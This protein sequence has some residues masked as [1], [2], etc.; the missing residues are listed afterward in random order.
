MCIDRVFCLCGAV[1]HLFHRNALYL[2]NKLFS[3]F[4]LIS[5]AKLIEYD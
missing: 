3:V 5:G 2:N 4:L 1:S